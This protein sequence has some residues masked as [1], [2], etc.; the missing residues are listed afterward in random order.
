MINTGEARRLLIKSTIRAFRNIGLGSPTTKVGGELV[1]PDKALE[2][3]KKYRLWL[4]TFR[5][6]LPK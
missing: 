5:P 4:K 2:E 1:W 3:Y 6:R